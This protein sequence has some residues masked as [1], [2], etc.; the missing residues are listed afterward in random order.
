MT[1]PFRP[2]ELDGP[3]ASVGSAAEQASMLAM[4]RELE[5]LAVRGGHRSPPTGSAIGSGR[6]CRRSHC[7]GPISAIVPAA[8]GGRPAALLLA[9]RDTWHVAWTGGR[10]FAARVPAIAFVLVLVVAI[11]SVGGLAAAGAF[12]LL[13]PS[14]P[15]IAP[16]GSPAPSIV[17]P[18][19][20]TAPPASPP[21]NRGPDESL[22][23]GDIG[24][25][26][27]TETP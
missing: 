14:S 25:P 12:G 9:L 26:T 13:G 16:P 19:P 11:G 10:P 3:G 22:V 5:A 8:R 18:A 20:S 1:V 27:E 7:L 21:S 2:S 15:T 6:R 4:A 24:R 23:P 17:A